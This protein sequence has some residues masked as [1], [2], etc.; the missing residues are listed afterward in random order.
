MDISNLTEM[1]LAL[2]GSQTT[3]LSHSGQVLYPL[4]HQGHFSVIL[5]NPKDFI[6]Q[7]ALTTN[8]AILYIMVRYPNNFIISQDVYW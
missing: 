5:L 4:D 3:H 8:V 7:T 2:G 6:C 1:F